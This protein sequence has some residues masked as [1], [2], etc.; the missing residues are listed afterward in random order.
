MPFK[1]FCGHIR[2]AQE[3]TMKYILEVPFPKKDTAKGFGAKWDP[4]IRKWYY[5]GERLPAELSRFFP[6][7]L[8]HP[9]GAAPEKAPAKTGRIPLPERPEAFSTRL[10]GDEKAEDPYAA[11]LSVTAL[12]QAVAGEL[13][14]NSL[15]QRILVRG[16]VTNYSGHKRNYYFSIK[17]EYSELPCY[18]WE[19]T[20]RSALKFELQNGQQVALSGHLEF[21]E[22]RGLA[23]FIVTA[24]ENIGEGLAKLRKL[25]LRARL[26][27][28]G[29][30]DPAHKKAIPRHAKTIGI[31][32]SLQGQAFRDIQK[33]A[34]KRCP[35]I[36]LVLYPVNVQGELAVKTTVRGIE[37]LD[38]YGVDIIIVGR[39]GGSDEDLSAYDDEQI[40]RAVYAAK[41][42]LI[43]AVGHAGN[44]SFTDDAADLFAATPSEAAE[45]AV[46]ET[47]AVISQIDSLS[48]ELSGHLR[49]I[50]SERKSRVL[51]ESGFLSANIRSIFTKRRH[52]I[53]L[54]ESFLRT[55]SPLAE[56]RRRKE[57]LAWLSQ[58]LRQSVERAYAER[59][60]RYELLVSA[61]HALSPSARLVNGF[62]YITL[63]D[64]PLTHASDVKPGDELAIR[65][66]DGEIRAE[67]REVA[68]DGGP[69]AD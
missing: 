39:G 52:E 59:D 23:Q 43:S 48:R 13:S 68:S 57:L 38:R 63:R 32:T 62:G 42:P 16:E 55:H 2:T 5:E 17:D 8:P 47:A 26:E 67:V 11:Y 37:V 60:R 34:K 10:S 45:A 15:F 28:E 29:L 56:L 66:H 14:K 69:S 25:R 46:S 21:Y 30:F 41:T 9:G 35:S 58:D 36:Q 51:R 12:N 53:E 3:Y 4:I 19:S 6:D 40:V 18:L 61:L 44:H 20:A 54:A 27:Q 31:V 49:R 33:I 7:A 64:R 24:I 65:V 1:S 50:L 22:Q